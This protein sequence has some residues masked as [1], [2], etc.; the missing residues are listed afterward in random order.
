MPEKEIIQETEESLFE[1]HRFVVDEKQTPIRIDKY[2]MDKIPKAS[3]NK[4][5]N[6]IKAASI[7]INDK[8]IK[9]NYKV[10][11]KDIITVVLAEP[12]RDSTVL[13]EKMD[14]NIVFE[15]DNLLIINK[16]AGLV[17]HPGFNNYSGTLVNGLVYHFDN[18]PNKDQYNRPGLVHRIDKNTTGLLVIAKTDLAMNHLAKQFFDH[19]IE[20]TYHTLVWGDFDEEEG[21]IEGNI[22]RSLRDRRIMQVFPEGDLGKSAISHYKVLERFG[23]VTLLEFRLETGR[24]HQIRTHCRYIKHPIFNDDTYGGDKILRGTIFT[25]YK[26]FI[27]NCFKILPRLA[28]HAKSLGFIHPI[29]N[30]RVYFESNLP[31]DFQALL[32]KWRNYVK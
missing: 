22:G 21:K 30:K 8:S 17:V 3:R 5:Q 29:T 6:G 23:Y 19:S 31:E 26:Q 32:D 9:S 16:P 12:P 1:H 20:R 18:L 11:P 13:P 14:L 24:T 15:D 2:L 7:L 28:L 25:K 4:I 10:K 27:D